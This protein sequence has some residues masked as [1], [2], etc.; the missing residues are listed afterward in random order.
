MLEW[1][2]LRLLLAIA[3]HGSLTAAARVLGVTQP[4]MGRRVENLED[5]LGARLFERTAA[6]V[7]LSALGTSLLPLAEQMERSALAA[8]RQIAARDTGLDGLVRITTLEWTG[9]HLLAPVLA[10]F[11][12]LHPGVTVELLTA[13]R[14]FSLTR[15]ETDIALRPVRFDQEGLVQRRIGAM[16][17]GL[18]ASR[19]YLAERG[20]PDFAAGCPGHTL[21]TLPDS[22]FTLAQAQWLR[23]TLA[24]QAHIALQSN[25][26]D[27]QAAAA[28]A[29]AG[30]ALLPRSIGDALSGLQRLHPPQTPPDRELW[31]GFH[32][33]LRHT[34]RVRALVDYIAAE[35]R[36]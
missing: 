30:L 16:P 14:V 17:R 22:L 13:D 20:E 12:R 7:A 3:R 15:H 32:E 24:P 27:V 25:S 1:D 31:L 35:M 8:E 26:L 34:L 6:G 21:I 2:D 23:D 33:D 29:G 4:T 5:R 18:Y 28:V 9:H 19:T 11:C 36:P 10:G